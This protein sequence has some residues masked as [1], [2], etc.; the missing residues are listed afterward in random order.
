MEFNDQKRNPSSVQIV[1]D[2]GRFDFIKDIGSG[3]FGITRLLK[4]KQS[5]E[6]V[7]IK[8][9]ER[10]SPV[11]LLYLLS[12]FWIDF[13][14]DIALVLLLIEEVTIAGACTEILVMLGSL[15]WGGYNYFQ[16]WFMGFP[17]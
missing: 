1:H 4:N 7:A 2:S 5:N 13:W 16:Y 17:L 14:G 3:N 10:G 12:V 6:Q 11:S 9:I 8:Y 15:V